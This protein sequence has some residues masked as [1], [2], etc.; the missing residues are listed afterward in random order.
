MKNNN[1]EKVFTSGLKHDFK[2]MLNPVIN[3]SSVLLKTAQDR[4]NPD[5][6]NYLEI[7][8]KNGREMLKIIDAADLCHKNELQGND[9]GVP[10][11]AANAAEIKDASHEQ[12]VMLVIDDD[13]DNLISIRAIMEHDFNNAFKIIHADSGREGID[14]LSGVKPDLILL[15][16]NLPDI[17]GLVLVKSIKNY[18]AGSKVPVIAFTAIDVNEYRSRILSAG[19]DDIIPKPFEIGSFAGKIKKWS[20]GKWL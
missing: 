15:D 13:P 20:G 18:F 5:E 12:S 16:I 3:L 10:D 14:I 6:L 8:L 19:F 7:I 11:D 4:L 9:R 1:S 17:S 2:N